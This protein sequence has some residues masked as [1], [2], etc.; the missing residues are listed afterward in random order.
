MD[1]ARVL[2]SRQLAPV[3]V[4]KDLSA[5]DDVGIGSV[6]APMMTDAADRGHK[7]HA[8]RHDSGENLG[9]MT[10]AAGLVRSLT[11]RR[12]NLATTIATLQ[13]RLAECGSS[14]LHA[15]RLGAKAAT[16][17]V[18]VMF[19]GPT[20]IPRL[21]VRLLRST[22]YQLGL[23]KAGACELLP[24]RVRALAWLLDQIG[25]RVHRKLRAFATS[26]RQTKLVFARCS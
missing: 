9:I 7:H 5:C 2:I 20:A 6:F 19:S 26:R 18:K 15:D 14:D 24:Q 4:S 25:H 10:G 23:R 21:N 1:E 16:A 3:G 8:C 13:K 22:C 11:A 17:C 12:D